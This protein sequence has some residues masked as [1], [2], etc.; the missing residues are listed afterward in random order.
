MSGTQHIVVIRLSRNHSFNTMLTGAMLDRVNEHPSPYYYGAR[1]W[2]RRVKELAEGRHAFLRQI[3]R[4][5]TGPER[6]PG[7]PQTLLRLE[8]CLVYELPNAWA[9]SEPRVYALLLRWYDAHDGA[10][11]T[12]RPAALAAVA[13]IDYR[14]CRFR[15]WERVEGRR[16]IVTP[17]WIE[18]SLRG[19]GWQNCSGRSEFAT[20]RKFAKRFGVEASHA[21]GFSERRASGSPG[22]G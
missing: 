16:G 9:Q 12:A 10:K 14:L 18:R 1:G 3:A 19:P 11:R 20:I 2:H 17:R 7:R 5:R 6:L 13:R 15:A 8:E 4:K 21:N 22:R